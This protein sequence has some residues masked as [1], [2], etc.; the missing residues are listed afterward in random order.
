MS[1]T[2]NARARGESEP[3]SDFFSE[4]PAVC[5]LRSCSNPRF[6]DP[7][8]GRAPFLASTSPTICPFP[9]P[10]PSRAGARSTARST[11][12]RLISG[13]ET[14]SASW[15]RRADNVPFTAWHRGG[16]PRVGILSPGIWPASCLPLSQPV[17]TRS[18]PCLWLRRDSVCGALPRGGA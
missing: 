4:T 18:G 13:S 10:S 11:S 6:G 15:G 1:R 2:E 7:R 3:E 5:L 8:A 14:Q 16:A 12:Y 9:S 17:P